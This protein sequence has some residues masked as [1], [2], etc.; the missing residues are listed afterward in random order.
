MVFIKK[1]H[2]KLLV[3]IGSD[4][5]LSVTS[6]DEMTLIF[7]LDLGKFPL[8][9]ISLINGRDQI[10]VN[11]FKNKTMFKIYFNWFDIPKKL[12]DK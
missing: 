8:R 10:L 3:A 11:T 7:K 6:L 1:E 4:T 12:R 2:I 5:I 9:K